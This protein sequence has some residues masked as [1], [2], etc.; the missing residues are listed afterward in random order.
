MFAN[1]GEIIPPWGVPSSVMWNTF[2]SITPAL[3]HL[4]S[5]SFVD[6]D[7]VKQPFVV[8]MV[9]ASL[10]VTLKHPLSRG[11]LVKAL[12]YLVRRIRT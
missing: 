2:F 8:D 4:R 10:Y 3:S 9:E 6:Y 11:L 1:V 7:I 12:V 5:I